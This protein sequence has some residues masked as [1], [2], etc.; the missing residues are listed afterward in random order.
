MN[1]DWIS[2]SS[3]HRFNRYLRSP[4][5]LPLFYRERCSGLPDNTSILNLHSG[6][7]WR[8]GRQTNT[9]THFTEHRL[10]T[11]LKLSESTVPEGKT[12]FSPRTTFDS[13]FASILQATFSEEDSDV[14]SKVR[15]TVGTILMVVNPPPL[16]AIAQLTGLEFKQA[17]LGG[18]T[19]PSY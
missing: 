8:G 11:I 9:N 15:T 16:S 14:D 18:K 1:Q 17:V 5:R 12:R 13:L 2:S 3:P 4:R 7:N 10:N 19:N 6:V